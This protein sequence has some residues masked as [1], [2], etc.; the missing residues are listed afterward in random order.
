MPVGRVQAREP[1]VNEIMAAL[2]LIVVYV[3]AELFWSVLGGETSP[4]QMSLSILS[5]VF[6]WLV[7]RATIPHWPMARRL[8]LCL[9]VC[10]TLNIVAQVRVSE[11]MSRFG[12][13]HT[14]SDDSFY[15]KSGSQF[16]AML[17]D[18]N[19]LESYAY[20][21]TS[22]PYT[23]H[24]GFIVLLGHLFSLIPVDDLSQLRL[25]VL[26]N[27]F[28]VQWLAAM[29]IRLGGFRP[30]DLGLLLL[31]LIIPGFDLFYFAGEVRK[32]PLIVLLV[33]ALMGR[34]LDLAEEK[35]TFRRLSLLLAISTALFFMRN[36]YLLLPA[37]AMILT[38]LHDQK[39]TA[40]RRFAGRTAAIVGLA[41]ALYLVADSLWFQELSLTNTWNMKILDRGWGAQIYNFPAIGP[42]V[43][44]LITP[45]PPP[46]TDLAKGAAWTDLMRS[47]GMAAILILIVMQGAMAIRVRAGVDKRWRTFFHLGI[48]IFL[49]SAYGSLEARHRL[50]ALPCLVICYGIARQREAA[51]QQSGQVARVAAG[52]ARPRPIALGTAVSSL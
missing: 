3:G 17:S 38:R 4:E 14:G 25:V 9:A 16:A 12:T 35:A 1:I 32:D 41:G 33:V 10:T 48:V 40:L 34:M 13:V 31:L 8:A 28:A 46:L 26:L 52:I 29:V 22:L 27:S 18:T 45:L 23:P 44:A 39:G 2:V 5:A 37:G 11:N 21:Y 36:F 15:L 7:V 19:D 42:I 24:V 47:V 30:R 20:V 6:T 43:Y 51:V 50:A 49:L